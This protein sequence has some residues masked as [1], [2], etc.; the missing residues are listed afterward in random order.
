MKVKV[1]YLGLIRQKIGRKEE[2]YDLMEG[3]LLRD[4]L[5]NIVETHN[6][7]KSIIK[8]KD[9]NPIDPTLVI[10]LNGLSVNPTDK[11]EIVLKNGDTV[12]LM[13]PIGGGILQA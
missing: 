9:E 10:M 5:N 3:Y 8:M 4:L 11:K 13:T 1:V 2:E 6:V 7:L 12:T